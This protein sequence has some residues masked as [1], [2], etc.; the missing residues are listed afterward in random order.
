MAD[1]EREEEKI[2]LRAFE[3]WQ[4][5]QADRGKLL[6]PRSYYELE[7][8]KELDALKEKQTTKRPLRRFAAW[9]ETTII[10]KWLED[11]A[12]LLKNAALLDI[13][14]LVAGVTIIISLIT[15]L[16]NERQ[17]RN[18]EVYQAWQVITAAYDQSGSG[19]RKEALEFLNSEQRR[20]PWFWLKWKR[21]S[22]SGL[23]APKAFLV[24]IQLPQASLDRANLQEASLSLANLQEASLSLA[25]LQEASL[26]RANLQEASLSLA[27]LQKASLSLA[28]L[29]EADLRLANLQEADLL[30]AN[31]QKADLSEVNLQEAGLGP[32]NLQEASLNQANLQKAFLFSAHFQEANLNQANLQ[33]A[34]LSLANLQEANLNQANLQKADLRLANLQEAVLEA[35]NLQGA[36]LVSTKNLTNSQIKS[37]C[38]WERAIYEASRDKTKKEWTVDKKANQKFIEQL[39]QDKSSDPKEKPDC[40]KWE[41][42]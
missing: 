27:N 23:A 41:P 33:E 22:L 30:Q 28:N 9:W 25:N 14:N 38:F 31:L 35:A 12:F 2:Q 34:S 8:R 17:R 20:F 10:E 3:L 18:A 40:S 7:A 19:G 37:A 36:F 6:F 21:Q 29:Q 11:I 32:A 24:K 13:V 42:K 16:V 4:A 5:A 15:F 39:K 26:N 1:T